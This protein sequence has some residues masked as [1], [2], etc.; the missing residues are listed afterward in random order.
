MRT[1]SFF[2]W[3]LQL[4]VLLIAGS[5][6]AQFTANIQGTVEDPSGAAVAQAKVVLINLNTQVSAETTTDSS[7]IY[8]F[9][10]LA[11]G[12][13][14]IRAESAG[15]AT[16]EKTVILQTNQNLSVPMAL[17][18]G[19]TS[20]EVTV[21]AEVPLVNAAETRNEQ[22]LETQELSTLP[23]AGRNM[24]S[25]ATLAPGA[26]GLGTQS[27]NAPGSGVDNFSTETAV[28]V[29]AN[30]Q[31]TVANMWIVDGL[32]VTSA[33][34][35]GVLNLT[36]NPDVVQEASTQ[37]NTFSAEYGRASSI[38]FAM[39]T[40]SGSDQ[41][42][43]LASDYFNYQSMYAKYSLPGSDHK[44][45]PFHSNNFS[46]GVGGPIVPHRQF[47]FFFAAEPL[48]S[49]TSTGNQTRTF[50]DAQFASWAKANYP[51]TFGTRILNTD[52]PTAVTGTSILK[53]AADIFPGTCGTSA[54]NNLPC[55][56]PMID[57]GI[58]NSTNFRNGDQYFVR[59]DKY[60]KN[61][62]I[63]GSFFRTILHYGGPNII[64]Q[65]STT[66]HTVQRALQGN[67]THTFSPQT[68]NEAIFAQNRIEGFLGETGDFTIPNISVTG[69]N[70]GYGVGFA[71]GN[72]IQHNYH[73]RD[74]LTHVRGA[75]VLKVGYEGWFGDDVEPFQGPWSHPSFSFDNLLK[76]AQD[77]PRTEGS[78]MYNPVTGQ[79]ELWEW[80]AAS[81][82]WGLFVQ[83]TWKARRNL[84]LTL[85][86]RFDDQGNPYSRTASTIFGNFYLGSGA[87]FQERVANGSA[88]P[89]MNALGRSPK[90]YVPRI[91]A[92]WD[93]N[94]KGDWVVHG[95]FGIFPNWLTPAYV[96]VEFRGY[97][98]GLI[99]PT[100]FAGTSTPPIFAPGNSSKPPFGFTFPP[101]AGSPLCPTAPCLDSK[102][103]IRGAQFG[104]GAI[105]PNI[106]SP[107]AYIFSATLE[108]RINRYLAAAVLYSGSH[109]SNLISAGDLAGQVSYGADINALPGDLLGKPP[110]S[111]PTRLNTSF[112]PISY[113]D[114]D[115]VG[116]Y[117]GVTFDLKGRAGRGFFDASYTRSSSKDDAGRYPTAINPHQFYGPSPWDAP[118][119]FSLSFNYELPGLQSGKGALGHITSGWGLSST[120]VYQSGYPF[121]VLTTA[122]FSAGGDY[123]ADG[124]NLDYPDVTSYSQGT[125]R[126]GFLSG[127]FSTGQFTRPT[128]GTQ[129]NEKVNQFRNPSFKETD[130]TAY[131]NT[132]LTEKIN[133]QLRFEFYNLFTRPNLGNVR[134]DL[135]AGNFGR[136]TSQFLPRW[137]QI[138]AKLTF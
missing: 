112:G 6:Y 72:F 121:T 2:S 89:A 66:N 3:A 12:S 48:R 113:T 108:H 43:G 132:K 20:E 97:P 117:N 4:F 61:D 68:L 100:F 8:R 104:I 42:H 67:W 45:N 83:D 53:T 85:G 65:F 40:K 54:T 95:G 77:A 17:K 126:S 129:G 62:R 59:V 7:G 50:P 103:G 102:G 56:T 107:A 106:V 79:Q 71:Q 14:K 34:R 29:S 57:S 49:S 23:L 58:F 133:L 105:N 115:R 124:D 47:F 11:P 92:A 73:W 81:K 130:L 111:P 38:Q 87:T 96:Q 119:R 78:V 138:G 131:K 33:I 31:G 39:T 75:H 109:S 21:S 35:Q 137:W 64:P 88:K 128:P 15:F 114:N 110:G 101:L 9:L 127:I 55:T 94:G 70:V 13:Y 91:G 136:V 10:S 28:D 90:T 37:V 30:G 1:R 99:L 24:I 36:P 118:N 120:N 125:S 22:T 27:S 74:V 44:Y 123:N 32:D 82:T 86:F 26:T 25:L 122:A 63:Y 84:T 76:L 16:A 60:F 80:N 19:A 18:V 134:N 116:N 52:V 51:N 135:S 46:F 93:V 69:Q 41:F 5:T 98:T